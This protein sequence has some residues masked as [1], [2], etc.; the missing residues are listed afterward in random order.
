MQ[1]ECLTFPICFLLL[2]EFQMNRPTQLVGLQQRGDQ[3]P[4]HD[5]RWKNLCVSSTQR[6]VPCNSYWN[7][8]VSFPRL[9][10]LSGQTWLKTST[11]NDMCT[12]SVA[13]HLET[14]VWIDLPAEICW[15]TARKR[16]SKSPCLT[17]EPSGRTPRRIISLVQINA[18]VRS[19]DVWSCKLLSPGSRWGTGEVLKHESHCTPRFLI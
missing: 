4:R 15:L 9:I 14:S 13:M 8:F 17:T 7:V 1:C 12:E 16:S 11:R 5:F 3:A 18:S 2:P 6:I 19:M 10:R